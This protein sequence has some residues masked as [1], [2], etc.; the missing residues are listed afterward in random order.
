MLNLTFDDGP[1]EWTPLILDVLAEH[2]RKGTFF[3]IGASVAGNGKTLQRMVSE[4][5]TIGNHTF[6]HRR[7]TEIP[8]KEVRREFSACAAV[9]EL[10]CGV[11]MKMW[12]APYLS[13][14]EKI[15]WAAEYFGMTHVG[16]GIDPLDWKQTSA[17]FI[18]R[19]VIAKAT[20][21]AT[22]C[23]HDGIPPDGGNGT[24]TRQAT[25]DALRLIL[26][27]GW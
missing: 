13:T 26:E 20:P 9:V 7:L 17:D 8:L 18:A 24:D 23:L 27:A 10:A 25:V 12:R 2:D 5:H 1:S 19:N 3:I 15:D 21:G 4:G 14:S 6:T 11:E 16:A 22:V